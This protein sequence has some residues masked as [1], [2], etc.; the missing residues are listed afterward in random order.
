MRARD[1][2]LESKEIAERANYA[3]TDFLARM[4]HE[5]RTPMNAILGFAQIIQMDAK[6]NNDANTLDSVERV[7]R[8]GKHL[9]ELINEVLDLSPIET[10]NLKLSLEPV[11][12]VELKNELME[13]VGP[14][15]DEKRIKIIDTQ[16]I[17]LE[18][19]L[20]A[21]RIRLK[22]VLLN[23]VSNGIKYNKTNGTLT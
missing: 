8:G 4:S 11:N 12:M 17:G 9:L 5:L 19:F 2:I 6:K 10:G 21:D 1:E 16:K 23:L 13:I 18:L 7:L 3:K 20:F 15:A 22:Q 14:L